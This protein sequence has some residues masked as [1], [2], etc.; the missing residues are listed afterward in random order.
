MQLTIAFECLVVFALFVELDVRSKR[1]R[2]RL[3][4]LSEED[5]SSMFGLQENIHL[6]SRV[7]ALGQFEVSLGSV[8]FRLKGVTPNPWDVFA[9]QMVDIIVCRRASDHFASAE[10]NPF[11]SLPN[12]IHQKLI[13]S[14]LLQQCLAIPQMRFGS[15]QERS[16]EYRRLQNLT[17]V[18]F[19]RLVRIGESFLDQ[20]QEDS[21]HIEGDGLRSAVRDTIR[22]GREYLEGIESLALFPRE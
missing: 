2:S 4:G 21:S 6:F 1:R 12:L 9:I 3:C 5:Y 8:Q 14:T 16:L 20:A 18:A 22:G 11:R 15:V 13:T 17:T 19:E 10:T 7:S